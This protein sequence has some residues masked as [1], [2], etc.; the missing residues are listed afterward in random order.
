M[1]T[2]SP[3]RRRLLQAGA[4]VG[5]AAVAGCTEVL[6]TDESGD[7]TSDPLAVVP[8]EA[9]F[10]GYAD[11]EALLADDALRSELNDVLGAAG[12]S[13]AA[14]PTTVDGALDTAADAAG[15]DPRRISSL[16]AFG[17]VD[18][19]AP[20]GVVV[21]S[22]WTPATLRS[23][24]SS[25]GAAT[26]SDSYRDTDLLLAEGLAVGT[27]QEG[28]FAAGDRPTVEAVIDVDSGD[29]P[30]VNGRAR[31]GFEATPD[32]AIRFAVAAP[33]DLGE[34]PTADDPTV[35]PDAVRSITHAYGSYVVDDQGRSALTIETDDT[36]AAA[37]LRDGVED[38][39]AEA[40]ATLAERPA[41]Q[42]MVEAV[43]TLLESVDVSAE[44]TTVVVSTATG[45]LLPV[46]GLAVLSSFFLGLESGSTETPTPQVAFEFEYEADTGR[47]SI[48]HE[49]GD[50]V[51]GSALS[52][53]GANHATGTWA[54]LGGT[55]S[56]DFDGNPAVVAGDTV[57]IEADPDYVA[58]VIW[59]GQD[60]RAGASATL[61]ID[62]GPDA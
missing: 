49:G 14:V 57:T 13:G 46:L 48:T 34:G 52:I 56:G 55:A 41:D 30:P 50:T 43:A 31:E 22:D 60:D 10:V 4:A 35:D 18:A 54:E 62:R 19:G 2:W 40:V 6:P 45:T 20:G 51:R 1:A 32:A 28:T 5:T 17:S 36:D 26:E 9:T 39:R 61:A 38:A 12:E 21:R 33:D 7:R 42:P 29:A 58:R 23:A 16:V 47:L 11:V 44:G 59:E 24:L 37:T 53:H 27:L 8:A 3:S 25:N 15:L